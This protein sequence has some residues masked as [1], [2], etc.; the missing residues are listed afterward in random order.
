MDAIFRRVQGSNFFFFCFILSIQVTTRLSVGC[1]F[2][3]LS[4]SRG[5]PPIRL[6]RRPIH[7]LS[8]LL[9]HL[10][11]LNP[12]KIYPLALATTILLTFL[13][14]LKPEAPLNLLTP[15]SLAVNWAKFVAPW[16]IY[17]LLSHSVLT[18][19]SSSPTTPV[20]KTSSSIFWLTSS[21]T[22]FPP[23]SNSSPLFGRLLWSPRL[24]FMVSR[25]ENSLD[26]DYPTNGIRQ[27]CKNKKKTKKPKKQKPF[28]EKVARYAT[29]SSKGTT[30]LCNLVGMAW[31]T[32]LV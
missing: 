4:R 32:V 29:V 1:F 19:F 18:F 8:I 20:S 13:K 26:T 9:I 30:K 7:L 31:S 16:I 23:F 22:C 17:L 24:F 28:A 12:V 27:K 3:L 15:P 10:P 2:S 5:L 14:L 25:G 6:L 11:L 21:S